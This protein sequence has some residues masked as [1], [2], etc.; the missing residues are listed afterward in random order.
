LFVQHRADTY[1]QRMPRHA[2]C[3]CGAFHAS[4]DAEPEAVV[5]CSCTECQRR[6]GSPFGEAAYFS[7]DQVTLSGEAREYVR[8]ADSGKAFHTFFC[9]TCGSSLYWF[10]ARDPNRVGIAVGA[11]A[12]A[13]FPKPTR[14]VFERSKADWLVLG[15]D[16]PG[17]EAGRD[18]SKTR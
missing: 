17:F 12:D 5:I 10:S 15:C 18:S 11:F 16:I 9:P 13:H 4:V 14:S 6:S 1:V 2:Q 8:T 3:Q 7:R